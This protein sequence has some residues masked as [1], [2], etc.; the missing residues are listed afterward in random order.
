MLDL[1]L[2]VLNIIYAHISSIHSIY[3]LLA[4]FMENHNVNTQLVCL[5]SWQFYIVFQWIM[6]YFKLTDTISCKNKMNAGLQ[7]FYFFY[8]SLIVTFS[9][10]YFSVFFKSPLVQ[11]IHFTKPKVTFNNLLF[12]FN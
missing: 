6:L 9:P 11:D 12:K 4:I 10:F 1:I 8:C 3:E 5:K 7:L 2:A